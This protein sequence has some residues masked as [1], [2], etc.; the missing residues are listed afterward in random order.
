MATIDTPI[1]TP[2]RSSRHT[3]T[4]CF[5][6]YFRGCAAP[7]R[8]VICIQLLALRR[9]RLLLRFFRLRA[10]ILRV[11]DAM[12]FTLRFFIDSAML[13]ITLFFIF[14]FSPIRYDALIVATLICADIFSLCLAPLLLP[15]RC[16]AERHDA[17]A[18]MMI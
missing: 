4:P 15:P 11:V 6:R 2:L 14:Y 8:V 3:A 10:D 9:Q 16:Y 12:L 18:M 1:R 17:A 13:L 5:R 7:L